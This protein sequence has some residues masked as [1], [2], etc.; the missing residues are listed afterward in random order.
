VKEFSINLPV[1]G[2][3]HRLLVKDVRERFESSVLVDCLVRL[4]LVDLDDLYRAVL[5]CLLY[6]CGSC[7]H[8]PNHTGILQQ[9]A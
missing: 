5:V 9:A 2:G 4:L 6:L 7:S 8:Q 3:M 1:A